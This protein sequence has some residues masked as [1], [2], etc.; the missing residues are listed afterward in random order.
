LNETFRDV[1]GKFASLD[2]EGAT[3]NFNPEVS[4]AIGLEM[5]KEMDLPIDL[6]EDFIA[7]LTGHIV[8]GVPQAWGQLM[9]S[10]VSFVVLCVGNAA[11]TRKALELST[12]T[13]QSLQTCPILINGDDGLVRGPDSFFRLWSQFSTL[14]GLKP[15]LGKVYHCERYANINS[16][17]FWL[18]KTGWLQHIPYVNMGLVCGLKR[19]SASLDASDAF[20]AAGS[21]SSSIG[22]RHRALL[23]S[24]PVDLIEPVHRLY[25][26]FNEDLLRSLGPVPWYVPEEFGGI[27]LC[28]VYSLSSLDRSRFL[29]DLDHVDDLFSRFGPSRVEQ[30]VVDFLTHSPLPGLHRLPVDA[31]LA[32][33]SLWTGSI[34]HHNS[35]NGPEYDMTEDDIGF[36][37]VST[38]YLCPR[39]LSSDLADPLKQLRRNQSLWTTLRRRFSRHASLSVSS[40][41]SPMD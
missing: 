8:D 1:S 14:V 41:V 15:S 21:Y 3:D 36:L 24:C 7:G 30:A 34:P 39:W 22:A 31:P 28:P 11:V 37:D 18:D 25:L 17:S 29:E 35:P 38:Y 5:C 12:G 32:V 6:T 9:G 13:C 16:T 33:R 23:S 4:N 19:S 27:G 26:S 10:L 20:D 40:R 2:Y